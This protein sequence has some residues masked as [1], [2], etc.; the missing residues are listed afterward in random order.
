MLKLFKYRP[1][2]HEF[3][4]NFLFTEQRENIEVD[5]LPTEEK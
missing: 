2:Y 1:T 4:C 5:Y 3:F